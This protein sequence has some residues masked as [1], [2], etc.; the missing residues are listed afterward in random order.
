MMIE[1]S[2]TALPDVW[3]LHGKH[4]VQDAILCNE[5]LPEPWHRYVPASRLAALEAENAELRKDAERGKWL[6]ANLTRL[7]IDTN[8]T[9]NR[10]IWVKSIT[11]N[12]AFLLPNKDSVRAAI[13]AA[14]A[15]EGK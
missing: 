11:I 15:K 1:V 13:D 3:V 9:I 12:E 5:A 14:R 2:A 4:D 8:R 6:I 10:D 7:C